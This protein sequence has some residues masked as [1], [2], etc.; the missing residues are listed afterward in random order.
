MP[1]IAL[2]IQIVYHHNIFPFFRC[3]CVVYK[4]KI[5]LLQNVLKFLSDPDLAP[6]GVDME[7]KDHT[8]EAAEEAKEEM[9]EKPYWEL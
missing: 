6:V 3:F 8:A 7:V 2:R 1:N 9:E 4:N 5:I